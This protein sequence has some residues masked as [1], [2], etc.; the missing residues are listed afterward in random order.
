MRLYIHAH[1]RLVTVAQLPTN[2]GIGVGVHT[3]IVWLAQSYLWRHV[4]GM[5]Q[6]RV[7]LPCQGSAW[8]G[9]I[10]TT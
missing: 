10:Y 7:V 4:P 1:E 2:H 9:I 5:R 3:L 8:K 6:E